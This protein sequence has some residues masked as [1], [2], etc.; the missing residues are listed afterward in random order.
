MLQ[1]S[2]MEPSEIVRKRILLYSALCSLLSGVLIAVIC[3]WPLYDSLQ[4]N[5]KKDLM[6]LLRIKATAVEEFLRRAED[7]AA[8]IASRT[9]IAEKLESYNKGLITAKELDSFTVPKLEDP[10]SR[11]RDVA[12]VWRLDAKGHPVVR[13][14]LAI[15]HEP[16]TPADNGSRGVTLSGPFEIGGRSFLCAAAPI[17]NRKSERIGT[18]LVL[19]KLGGLHQIMG[20]YHDRKPKGEFYLGAAGGEGVR[21]LYPPPQNGGEG[22]NH[23]QAAGIVSLLIGTFKKESGIREV[24]NSLKHSGIVAYGPLRDV[25]WGIAVWENK[26]DVYGP[27]IRHIVIVCCWIVAV[28]VIATTGMLLVLNPLVGKMI[29]RSGDLENEVRL[30]TAELERELG[31][32]R[33]AEQAL[34]ESERKYRKI[35]EN[36]QDVFYQTDANGAVVDISPSVHRYSGYTREELIGKSAEIF[37]HNPE[38]RIRLLE[39]IHKTGEIADYEV[40]IKTRDNRRVCVSVNAH[41]LYD[42]EGRPAGT[43]GS[44]RDITE[45][46]QTE[47]ALQEQYELQRVLLSTI[48]AC[49][50]IKNR[51]SVYMAANKE[52]GQLAGA[53]EDEIPGKTDHHFF[54]KAL[55]EAFRKKDEEVMTTGRAALNYE[56]SLKD[57]QGNELWFQTSKCPFYAPSGEIAGLVGISIDTTDKK[58]ADQERLQ[59]QQRL[60]QVE[61]AESLARMGGAIAHHFNNMLGIVIGNLELALLDLPPNSQDRASIAEAMRASRRAV[62]LS[63]LMLTYLGQDIGIPAPLNLAELCRHSLPLLNGLVPRH[64]NLRAEFPTD[65]TIIIRAD[66]LRVRRILS[67]LVLNAAEAIG[68]LGGEITLAVYSI[69]AAKIPSSPLYP[70][71]W[72]PKDE[73]YACLSISDTGPGMDAD[74]LDRLFDPFF[75]TK[76]TGRGLGLAVVLGLVSAYDGAISVESSSGQGT[77]FKLFLPLAQEEPAP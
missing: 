53:P 46:K 17:V 55:A 71:T 26:D 75:S 73:A 39:S 38:D 54:P 14:G 12:G 5:A 42:S 35:F 56:E 31:E 44:L 22:E 13:I 3:M 36:V 67:N 15:D 60:Q 76:F 62:E 24:G 8:Q 11:A 40:L 66:E 25:P 9:V 64:V 70:L 58:R 41:L 33:Q 77:L 37:Y 63:R 4:A 20:D 72:E 65:R 10:V 2:H 48:P 21:F 7:I 49:V 68:D 30:K 32:R 61:K 34:G 27:V 47:L 43:E 45:R 29:I 57:T 18:D 52:F 69:P 1:S 16:C 6:L 50:Y 59:L 51:D 23:L 74:T 19:F 28:I